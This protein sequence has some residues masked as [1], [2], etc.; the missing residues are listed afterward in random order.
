MPSTGECSITVPYSTTNYRGL[1]VTDI[2]DNTTYEEN[3]E[4][5]LRCISRG[6]AI[7]VV[8]IVPLLFLFLVITVLIIMLICVYKWK[9][10]K[11]CFSGKL[12]SSNNSHQLVGISY[13]REDL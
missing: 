9:S 7:A 1:V 3:V 12:D 6:W 5:R 2:Y 4:I 8:I 11:T 10:I 13:K